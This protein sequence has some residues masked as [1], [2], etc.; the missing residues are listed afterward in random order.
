MPDREYLEISV[1]TRPGVTQGCQSLSDI[2]VFIWPGEV[3]PVPPALHV[4]DL[5]Y[6]RGSGK[7]VSP[8]D[9]STNIP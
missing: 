8:K 7:F 4:C 1:D 2:G 6:M 9:V 3:R 5:G